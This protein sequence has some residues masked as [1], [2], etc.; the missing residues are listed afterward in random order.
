MVSEQ[1]DSGDNMPPLDADRVHMLKQM[2]QKVR[3]LTSQVGEQRQQNR[4][5]VKSLELAVLAIQERLSRLSFL[6]QMAKRWNE[7]AKASGISTEEIQSMMSRVEPILPVMKDIQKIEPSRTS[8]EPEDEDPP[9]KKLVD[10]DLMTGEMAN[11]LVISEKAGDARSCE[12]DVQGE[13]P[14]LL[15]KTQSAVKKG[16]I[17]KKKKRWKTSLEMQ[18]SLEKSIVNGHQLKERKGTE[19]EYAHQ[20]LDT[21]HLRC[22]KVKMKSKKKAGTHYKRCKCRDEEI[23]SKRPRLQIE[24]EPRSQRRS[25]GEWRARVVDQVFYTHQRINQ[26][27]LLRHIEKKKGRAK[28]SGVNKSIE[29]LH[30]L[31][32]KNL[33]LVTSEGSGSIS[34]S[35]RTCGENLVEPV[36][37][38]GGV[39]SE[40]VYWLSRTDK[41]VV[42]M[43]G[44]ILEVSDGL[45]HRTFKDGGKRV[46]PQEIME[47]NRS[48][49]LKLSYV[50]KSP[51]SKC[52]KSAL[53]MRLN[54]SEKLVCQCELYVWDPGLWLGYKCRE[55]EVKLGYKGLSQPFP[56]QMEGKLDNLSFS[57]AVKLARDIGVGSD[58]SPSEDAVTVNV[59]LCGKQWH[60]DVNLGSQ[61]GAE[62]MGLGTPLEFWNQHPPQNQQHIQC[63][64]GQRYHQCRVQQQQWSRYAHLPEN[65]SHKSE[66]Q[67]MTHQPNIACSN[68]CGQDWKA[69]LRLPPP[70]TRNEITDVA[71]IVENASPRDGFSRRRTPKR[72]GGKLFFTVSLAS[73]VWEPGEVAVTQDTE[74]MNQSGSKS[75]EDEGN[76]S[77]FEI[78]GS[79]LLHSTHERFHS[80]RPP[81][82]TFKR[83]K[84]CCGG[85]WSYWWSYNLLRYNEKDSDL[86]RFKFLLLGEVKQRLQYMLRQEEELSREMGFC[87]K[88]LEGD[89]ANLEEAMEWVKA[90]C[91]Q[92]WSQF[93]ALD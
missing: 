14:A 36:D 66:S 10:K 4:D 51:G 48:P 6:E 58:S 67:K 45:Q 92:A 46:K 24:N 20:V 85:C 39:A 70:D 32:D 79:V 61:Y 13:V 71:I 63:E 84:Q 47:E 81:E 41:S 43:L 57:E 11:Q 33:Q 59:K 52:S 17:R 53:K 88:R 12:E 68:R 54:Y 65:A 75:V 49:R 55:A 40:T 35:C 29:D 83:L 69:S 42:G 37:I 26:R 82:M 93:K 7:E 21:M 44:K 9:V 89:D 18:G 78:L 60:E 64:Q 31:A 23:I 34:L 72:E 87:L 74:D 30:K 27:R 91:I 8:S 86:L 5:R 28:M 1:F 76:N 15:Q 25:I 50:Q 3:E 2:Q 80:P 22:K 62:K 77:F 90:Y 38:S 16:K 19:A 73:R 56:A